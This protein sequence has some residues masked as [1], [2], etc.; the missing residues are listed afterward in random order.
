MLPVSTNARFLAPQ[1]TWPCD[2]KQEP[3]DLARM[4]SK[5][6]VMTLTLQSQPQATR[7]KTLGAFF[8]LHGAW[9]YMRG[10]HEQKS[11]TSHVQ[12]PAPTQHVPRHPPRGIGLATVRPWSQAQLA[13]GLEAGLR[14]TQ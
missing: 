9:H 10:G 12:G 3:R 1:S 2:F 6:G 8:A 13:A 14:L 7:R 11:R 4:S 5:V